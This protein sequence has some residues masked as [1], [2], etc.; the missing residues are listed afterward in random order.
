ML[1]VVEDRDV[2]F[3]LEP[4]LDLEAAWR[5]DVLEQDPAEARSD[6]L[7]DLHDLVG[8]L[9]VETQR[10]RVDRAEG[11]EEHGLALHDRH[12]RLR[13]D[14]AQP[15]HRRAVRDD[16]DSV[17]LHGQRPRRLRVLVDRHGN[18]AHAGRVD[19]GEIRVRR[20]RDLVADLDLPVAVELEGAV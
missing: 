12:C 10:P 14:V 2:E 9:R 6:C 1:I 11:L 15:Q 18:A 17:G 16:G 7:H 20:D 19:V 4:F 3:G 13:S 5:G 8:V